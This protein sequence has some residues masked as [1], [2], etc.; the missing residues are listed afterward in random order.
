MGC[1]TTGLLLF[2]VG[3][4]VAMIITLPFL[5]WVEIRKKRAKN[6]AERML[7]VGRIDSQKKLKK[8]LRVLGAA[9][10]DLQAAQLWGQLRDLRDRQY[11]SG[12]GMGE[13][14][15]TGQVV[16]CHNCGSANV[17]EQAFCGDCGQKLQRICPQCS[18]AIDSVS[19]FCGQCGA[20][21][22]GSR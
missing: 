5:L 7:R 13:A 16:R 4:A 3:M 10:K 2:S 18:A 12:I 15:T 17:V 14:Q 21:V 8:A 22:G 6:E 19:R 9:T 20:Q 1:L 11:G